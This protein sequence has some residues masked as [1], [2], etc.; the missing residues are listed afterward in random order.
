MGSS[1]QLRMAQKSNEGF[2]MAASASLI[3][4]AVYETLCKSFCKFLKSR[5]SGKTNTGAKL[6]QKQKHP[7]TKL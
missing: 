5:H 3:R 6:W 4:S 1:K 7:H 2:G